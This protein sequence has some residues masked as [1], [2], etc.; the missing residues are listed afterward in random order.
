MKYIKKQK[1]HWVVEIEYK[2]LGYAL[3]LFALYT[4]KYI[5]SFGGSLLNRG[6]WLFTLAGYAYTVYTWINR[7]NVSYFLIITLLMYGAVVTGTFLN[8]GSIYDS[9]WYT[10]CSVVIVMMADNE[11]ENIDCLWKACIYYFGIVLF[12][13]FLTLIM[14]PDG[15]FKL[16][17]SYGNNLIEGQANWF[18]SSQNGM[19]KPM[20]FLIYFKADSDLRRY[21]H[22]TG[23]FYLLS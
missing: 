1:P 7:R 4:P 16:Y 18:Y 9:I 6:L 21:R 8:H 22:L 5:A 23:S 10:F 19:G 20:L 17:V 3:L 14:Y 2:T 12:I 11:S 15:M 13:N